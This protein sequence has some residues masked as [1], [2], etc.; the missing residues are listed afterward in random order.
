MLH[1]QKVPLFNG[2]IPRSAKLAWFK[3]FFKKVVDCVEV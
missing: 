1:Q 3:Q 2:F